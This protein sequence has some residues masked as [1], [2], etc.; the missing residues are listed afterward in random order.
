LHFA[1]TDKTLM[2]DLEQLSQLPMEVLADILRQD[3]ICFESELE[4]L[5]VSSDEQAQILNSYMCAH[6]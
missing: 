6:S 1:A 2:K 3:D 5:K 4:V